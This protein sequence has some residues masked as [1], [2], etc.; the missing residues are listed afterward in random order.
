MR[1]LS[2]I[3]IYPLI[4]C[5]TNCLQST[6]QAIQSLATVDTGIANVRAFT[7]LPEGFDPGKAPED[8]LARYGLSP[9][10]D[11]E[12]SPDAFAVWE[13]LVDAARHRIIP[14]LK[15]TD[16]YHGI[17]KQLSV[18][19]STGAGP[20]PATSQNWS[21]FAVE[22]RANIFGVQGGVW[23]WFV[24]PK[25]MDCT[26]PDIFHSA[27]WVGLDGFNSNDVL[28]T[29]TETDVD[30]VAGRALSYV[31]IEWFPN[32]SIAVSNLGATPGDLLF[33]MAQWSNNSTPP[34]ELT[35]FNFSTKKSAHFTMTPP[36]GTQPVGNSIE[37]IVERPSI[38][39]ALTKLT[40]F[41][42]NPWRMLG[43]NF[44]SNATG[45]RLVYR[46]SAPATGGS[47]ILT[48]T[49]NTVPLSTPAL[50][51]A[52]AEDSAWFHAEVTHYPGQ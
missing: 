1:R 37:W 29:G 3:L 28:Q 13:V 12:K 41:Y 2:I 17:V 31:W 48:M 19:K 40:P 26:V 32:P 51:S 21:G 35:I 8:E 36:A 7:P 46:P 25:A 39:G 20:T 4:M 16:V 27:N 30:C 23:G 45:G 24:V 50:F 34:P 11:K 14:Q 52:P 18:E 10:P 5:S 33:V 9:K 49:N 38:N 42:E 44:K 47:Y 43:G 15:Q 22:D 6:A